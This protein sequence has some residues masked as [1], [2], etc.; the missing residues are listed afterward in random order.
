MENKIKDAKALALSKN[1]A[2]DKRGALLAMKQMKMYEQE[3]T[4]LDG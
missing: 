4:K 3:V 1:K 2:G